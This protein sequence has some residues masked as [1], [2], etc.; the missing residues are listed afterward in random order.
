[1]GR[2]SVS[3]GIR[4]FLGREVCEAVYFKKKSMF[5][6][7]IS[8]GS[9]S[10]KN[11]SEE[12]ISKKQIFKKRLSK[13]RNSKH[14]VSIRNISKQSIFSQTISKECV[15]NQVGCSQGELE[16]K[17]RIGE[18]STPRDDRVIKGQ[19][20]TSFPDGSNTFV[21][22]SLTSA[23]TYLFNISFKETTLSLLAFIT[24]LCWCLR[25]LGAQLLQC[26]FVCSHIQ[27]YELPKRSF[28][29]FIRLD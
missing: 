19:G 28:Q 24:L 11:F 29:Y 12:S 9:I 3:R 2:G 10:K 23:R 27:P 17:T 1:M 26:I 16:H 8:K 15:L 20:A 21:F 18:Q 5:I 25:L 22:I 6:D 4:F 14:S 13:Q 7:F